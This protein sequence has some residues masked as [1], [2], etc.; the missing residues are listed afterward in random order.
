MLQKQV[1]AKIALENAIEKVKSFAEDKRGAK[2]PE[3]MSWTIGDVIIAV[4][5]ITAIGALIIT[6]VFPKFETKL[7]ELFNIKF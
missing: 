2:A 3:E 6:K 4:A 7:L 5:V 1:E